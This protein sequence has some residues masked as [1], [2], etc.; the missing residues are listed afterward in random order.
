MDEKQISIRE[1]ELHP[2]YQMIA[3]II[4]LGATVKL[5]S[6]L[7]GEQVYFPKTL[8]CLTVVRRKERDNKIIADYHTNKFTLQKL[9]KKYGMTPTGI[10]N[11]FV[12][13]NIETPSAMPG[14]LRGTALI[15][16][17]RQI[18]IEMNEDDQHS[19]LKYTLQKSRSSS[20]V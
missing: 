6:E 13:N 17:V 9:S 20:R 10:Y 3:K 5:G 18:L 4:G 8:E 14:M 7:R 11:V 2:T 19:V 12:R 16:K 15:E 1:N